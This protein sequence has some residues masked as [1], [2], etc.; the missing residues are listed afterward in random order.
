[1]LHALF[2]NKLKDSFK[3]ASFEPSEDSLTSSVFGLL[4]YLP[5]QTMWDLLRQSCG[6]SS[7]LPKES[8]ELQNIY[9]W[10][11]WSAVGKDIPNKY[12]V[13][14]DIFCKF[15][16]FDLIIEA[17]KDDQSGQNEQQWINEINAYMNEYNNRENKLIFFAIGGNKTFKSQI[18]STR[19][20][21]Q[22]VFSASW[23]CLLSNVI[24][25]L[26]KKYSNQE[27]RILSDIIFAFEKHDF[28]GMELIKTLVKYVD[29]LEENFYLKNEEMNKE[30]Q[31]FIKSELGLTGTPQE[32]LI[33]LE[34]NQ[35][36]IKKQVEFLNKQIEFLKNQ[37]EE[38]VKETVHKWRSS[39]IMD[40]ANYLQIDNDKLEAGIILEEYGTK[41][42]VLLEFDN[43]FNPYCQVDGNHPR[44]KNK[45]LPKVVVEKVEHLLTIDE[46][47]YIYLPLPQHFSSDDLYK[48]LQNVIKALI[49]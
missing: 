9:F 1:M 34:A 47:S 19:G 41:I 6:N 37:L 21:E 15:D 2:N 28:F 22:Y 23:Q 10:P 5:A 45:K 25:E 18:I 3:N 38:E 49:S 26:K 35:V 24:D 12:K 27:Q 17:K 46:K 43:V 48:F 29:H 32:N 40:Y 30:F 7:S 42:R 16:E 31:E 44:S 39:L 11:D 8:G 33:K 14:P 13:Q 4:Q 20:G 36:K